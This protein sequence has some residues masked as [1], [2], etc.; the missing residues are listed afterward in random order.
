MDEFMGV[1]KLFAGNFAPRG[2]MFCQ[3]QTLSIAQN[4]ALFSLLGTT[5]GGDGITTFALPN[6]SGTTALGTGTSPQSGTQYAIAERGGAEQV[7]MSIANMP[8]HAHPI[9]VHANTDNAQYSAPKTSSVLAAIVRP[10]GRE[11]ETINGYTDS[12]PNVTMS[13]ATATASPVGGGQPMP[14][15]QPYLVMNYIICTQ[16]IYPPRP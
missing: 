7:T 10:N 16:G 12:S 5:Y 9:S 15:M 11:F 4:T 6:L 8:S 3:G 1:I 14:N 2:W 13:T